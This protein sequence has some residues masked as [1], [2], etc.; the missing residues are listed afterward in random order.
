MERNRMRKL[1]R[2]FVLFIVFVPLLS[3]CWS[4]YELTE[5]GFVMGVALDLGE[6]GD[7]EMLTQIYRPL[8]SESG[9]TTTTS[10][11]SINVKTTDDTVMESIRDIPIHLGRKAQWSHMRVIIVGEALARSA[12]ISKI[13]D[14]FLR[15][16]EPRSSVSLMIARGRASKM[17]EKKPL[18]EQTTAQQFLRTEES[19]Y[20]N[21]AKT[22]DT[23]LLDLVMQLKSAH[24]DAVVAYVYENK[25]SG[26]IFSAA[27]LALLKDG[28]MKTVLPSSKV[29]G[30]VMLRNEYKAGVAQIA[31]PGLKGFKETAEV[32]SLHVKTK[33][34]VNGDEI[35]VAVK[36]RGE[37]AITELRCTRIVTIQDERK[38]VAA[39]EKALKKQAIDSIAFVQKQ[40]LDV[41]GIG[42]SIYRK[43][44]KKWESL[45]Q[46]WDEQFAELQFDIQVELKLV[47]GG[48]IKSRP[49]Y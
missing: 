15:D 25:K 30:L 12:D 24:P 4:K 17:F 33:P 16:H 5:R 40:K 48:T 31:C 47:T 38:F 37:I 45:K 44:P 11:L 22:I 13:L 36:M 23:S 39:V 41:I 9:K 18:I 26:D 21:S 49:A 32:L 7:I 43:N 28:V 20:R 34:I 42:N 35:K 46:N 2:A 19:S 6:E 3:G 27:G 29:E 1:G 10:P 8:S 14:L